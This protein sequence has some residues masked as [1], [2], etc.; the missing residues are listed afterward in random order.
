M[1]RL[2]AIDPKRV[3]ILG[4][5]R[6]R[7]RSALRRPQPRI[8]LAPR[9]LMAQQDETRASPPPAGTDSAPGSV[10]AESWLV[11]RSGLR[12]TESHPSID[13]L[14]RQMPAGTPSPTAHAGTPRAHRARSGPT[15]SL[16]RTRDVV[17]ARLVRPAIVVVDRLA[18]VVAVPQHR[19]A[20]PHQPRVRRVQSIHQSPRRIA[21]RH[22]RLQLLEQR[23]QD[24]DASGFVV[25][26]RYR[27]CDSC[28][29]CSALRRVHGRIPRNIVS[30]YPIEYSRVISGYTQLSIGIYVDPR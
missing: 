25:L 20:D 15:R 12:C 30:R 7:H 3:D 2:H 5:V 8:R 23:V 21:P 1:Q 28:S 4:I 29:M 13:R 27:F 6:P 16:S 14:C 24:P 22:L 18:E 9:D 10:P 26:L 11:P 19:S 17:E